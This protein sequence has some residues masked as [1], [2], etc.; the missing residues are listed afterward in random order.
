MVI[1]EKKQTLINLNKLNYP[2]ILINSKNPKEIT[3][4][5]HEASL[6]S[7]VENAFDKLATQHRQEAFFK[8]HG[9]FIEPYPVLDETNESDDQQPIGYVIP[10]E[11]K[12]KN[13][14]SN[15][16]TESIGSST[17]DLNILKA[18]NIKSNISDGTYIQQAIRNQVERSGTNSAD[19]KATLCFVLYYDDIEIVN[20]I[21]SAKKKHKLGIGQ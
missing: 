5:S 9:E 18:L 13:L 10:F 1:G 8:E 12:L 7:F 16:E 20:P 14:L 19:L 11:E 6:K 17:E 21:G 15:P 4:S 3:S 2:I